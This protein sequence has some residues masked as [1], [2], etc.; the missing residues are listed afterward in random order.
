M[1]YSL[2]LVI[3]IFLAGNVC[4]QN[5]GALEV[6]E[7][8]IEPWIPKFQLEYEGC[9]HFGESESESELRLFFTD[10]IVV[11]QIKQGYWEKN[12]GF[13][14]WHFI[15]LTN[16]K[17]D[18]KGNFSSNQYTG[19]FIIHTDGLNRYKGLKID[20]PWTEWIVG[21]NKYEIGIRLNK[22]PRLLSGKYVEASLRYLKAE[23]LERLTQEEL[24][25]MR[26]EIFARYGLKFKSGGLME[27][28]FKQKKWYR[29]QHESVT[30]FLTDLELANIQLI[31]KTEND[32]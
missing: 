26:N 18:K 16:V 2:T 13:W 24:K 25:I 12:T 30:E 14:K 23:E 3:L 31:K 28:Y 32:K 27:K 7:N 22:S 11:A 9:F 17:I 20:N 10:S 21:E 15:N 29:S 4:G 5:I 19:Q 1:K 6:S 8:T